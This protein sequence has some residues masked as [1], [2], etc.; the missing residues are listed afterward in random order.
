MWKH[1]KT[2]RVYGSKQKHEISPFFRVL[3]LFFSCFSLIFYNL[4][5][6]FVIFG[7]MIML[8]GVFCRFFH[9]FSDDGNFFGWFVFFLNLSNFLLF[10]SIYFFFLPLFFTIYLRFGNFFYLIRSNDHVFWPILHFLLI[11]KK[12]WQKILKFDFF[13]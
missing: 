5:F 1:N 6:F 3:T 10:P 4:V 12:I 7:R 9:V 13:F 11:L 8:L 2:Y